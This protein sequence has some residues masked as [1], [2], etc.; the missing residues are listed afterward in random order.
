MGSKINLTTN[1]WK[2]PK[3]HQNWMKIKILYIFQ[4]CEILEVGHLFEIKQ[5]WPLFPAML[6]DIDLIF[7]TWVYNDKLQIKFT[8]RSGPMIFGRVM[9]NKVMTT[10]YLAKFQSLRAITRPKIIGPERD[11]NLICNSLLYT[12]IPKIKSVPATKWP[13]HI[14]LPMS[15]I[16]K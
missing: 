15:V 4:I 11:V 6:W 2:E 14:V 16:P 13:G 10:K 5:L 9:W 3:N 8:F 1:G 7:G 12:H